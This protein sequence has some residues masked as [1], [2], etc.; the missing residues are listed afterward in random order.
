MAEHRYV[1]RLWVDVEVTADTEAD[2]KK[3]A[4][5]ARVDVQGVDDVYQVQTEKVWRKD[6]EMLPC[7]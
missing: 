3:A 5:K 4:D 1:V 6:G 2:A 7:H